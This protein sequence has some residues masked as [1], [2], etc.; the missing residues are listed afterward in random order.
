MFMAMNYTS[1]PKS[2][3]EDEADVSEKLNN[4]LEEL[5]SVKLKYKVLK[6]TNK[7]LVREKKALK[8]LFP[9]LNYNLKCQEEME[10]VC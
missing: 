3:F 7:G 8:K 4:A 9:N 5:G 6:E 1:A 2:I 10:T